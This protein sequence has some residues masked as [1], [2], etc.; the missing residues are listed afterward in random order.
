MQSPS[1]G[2]IGASGY[3]GIELS[4]LL[5]SHPAQVK[6]VTSDRWVGLPV[7]T[8]T[9]L[10]GPVG[11]LKYVSPDQAA[12]LAAGCEVVFLATPAEVSLTHAPALL[13]AGCRVIDLSGAFRLKQ[14][15]S[16]PA[17]YGFPHPRGELLAEAVYGL[18]ELQGRERIKNAKLL[19]NPGCYATA[20]ALSVAPLCRADL[21]LPDSIAISAASGVTGAGRKAAEDYSFS[22]LMDDFRPYK[23]LRHQHTPEIEQ[24]IGGAKIAFT[25]HLLPLKRGIVSTTF[26]RTRPGVTRAQVAALFADAYGKEPFIT[27]VETPD[28]VRLNAVVGTNRCALSFALEGDRLVVVTAI[29]NLVKGAAGAAVQNLNIM[30]GLDETLAL[31]HLVAHH[32]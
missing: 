7:S 17:A 14:P 15:Q 31:A 1:V 13:S 11:A 32:P 24:T 3:S 23:V 5:A 12:T 16:Y 29:D 19:A 18:P 26:T 9:G 21:I 22:E 20:A 30:L 2:I 8:H 28:Q 4:K 25:P 6:F 27:I 10:G